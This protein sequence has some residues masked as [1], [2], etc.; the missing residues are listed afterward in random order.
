MPSWRT[1]RM[2]LRVW[3]LWCSSRCA[4]LSLKRWLL[5]SLLMT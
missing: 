1:L 3:A 5:P 2:L 4:Q